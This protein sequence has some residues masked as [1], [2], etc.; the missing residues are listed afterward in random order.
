MPSENFRLI[1]ALNVIW[2][3]AKGNGPDRQVACR[4]FI[5]KVAARYPVVLRSSMGTGCAM[6]SSKT[7]V[8]RSVRERP[9]L[10]KGEP[11]PME[12]PWSTY[13]LTPRQK[14]ILCLI[15]E[16]LT[17][18]EIADKTNISPKTVDFHKRILRKK[19]GKMGTAGLVRFA[20]R[21]G[22]VEA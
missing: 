7:F 9:S 14:D 20:I 2:F 13:M 15:A 6:H 22:F 5:H 16:D 10:A 18:K 17:A 1:K 4:C 12:N 3:D 21:S 11:G 8:N 19:L